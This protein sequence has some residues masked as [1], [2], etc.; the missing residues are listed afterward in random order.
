MRIGDPNG[1]EAARI[2]S[3][4]NPSEKR[5]ERISFE[6]TYVGRVSHDLDALVLTVD[7]GQSSYVHRVATASG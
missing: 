2:L 7:P 3:R 1:S 6:P 5:P 4:K